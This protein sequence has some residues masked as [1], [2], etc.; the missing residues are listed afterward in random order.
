MSLNARSIK[1]QLIFKSRLSKIDFADYKR[2]K[3]PVI[4]QNHLAT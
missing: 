2:M 1:A 4:E 3:K